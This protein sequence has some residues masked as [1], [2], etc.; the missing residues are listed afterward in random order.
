M[1]P[2]RVLTVEKLRVACKGVAAPIDWERLS[3]PEVRGMLKGYI[4]LV[5]RH[6]GKFY[7][8]DW[9]SNLL[10]GY[11][12]E[13]ILS[14]MKR[15]HYGL[16]YLLYCVAL[17]RQLSERIPGFNW[18]RDFGGVR[19]VFLRGGMFGDKPSNALIERLSALF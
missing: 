12:S 17:R 10:P 9:K 14:A 1:L 8:V 2:L 7:L 13:N 16:Q 5:I 11:D 18:D 3:F 19:Y 4:D 15:G 6:R